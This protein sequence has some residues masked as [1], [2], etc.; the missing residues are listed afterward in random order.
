[1]NRPKPIPEHELE[2]QYRDDLD[3]SHGT[4]KI[5]GYEYET[6]QALESVDPTAFRCG[7]TDWLSFELDERLIEVDGEYFDRDD[8]EAFQKSAENEGDEDENSNL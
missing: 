2:Q 7:F 5:A 3:E 1:M 6:S 4:V 8:Y